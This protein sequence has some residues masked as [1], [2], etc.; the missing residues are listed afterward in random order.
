M[1]GYVFAAAT[2]D[3]WHRV[4]RSSMLYPSYLPATPPRILHYGLLC[5]LDAVAT[6]IPPYQF[7]KH[8]HYDFDVFSCAM[9][10]GDMATSH[11]RSGLFP[12]PP[13]VDQLTSPPVRVRQAESWVG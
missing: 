2:H 13:S 3:M 1:Y 10:S 11:G 9:A 7:D 4:D 6:G 12:Q 5:K 8:W